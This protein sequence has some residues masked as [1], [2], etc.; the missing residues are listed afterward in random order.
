M[1]QV[2]VAERGKMKVVLVAETNT[3]LLNYFKI[4]PAALPQVPPHSG[5]FGTFWAES[6]W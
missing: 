6:P 3:G 2:A 1:R 4:D 5:I